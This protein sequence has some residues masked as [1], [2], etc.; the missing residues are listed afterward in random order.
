MIVATCLYHKL[1]CDFATS[2]KFISAMTISKLS[3]RYF[4][5]RSMSF[6]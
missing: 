1:K 5:A 6:H 2:E 4:A 3:F